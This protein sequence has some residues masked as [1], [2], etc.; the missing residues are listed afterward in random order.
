MYFGSHGQLKSRL[1]SLV[2]A[3]V[4]WH[5][6]KNGDKIG[7]LIL[8]GEQTFVQSPVSHRKGVLLWLKQIVD[9]YNTGLQQP[10]ISV[11]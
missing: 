7:G 10:S 5:A 2:A 4:A 11:K 6:L 8:C 1:A 3:A 9:S